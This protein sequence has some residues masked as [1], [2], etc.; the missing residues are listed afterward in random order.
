MS[1]RERKRAERQKRKRRSAERE[2]TDAE[3]PAS[4]NG[5]RP[6]TRSELKDREAREALVPLRED[7]RP[8]IVTAAAVI[9]VLLVLLSAIGYALWDVL[10]DDARPPV[11][12]VAVFVVLFSVMAWGLWRARYWAVLGFQTVLVF[13]L[14]LSSLALIQATTV[15]EAVGDVALMAGAGF[16]FYRMVKAMAR[17]QMPERLPR[18]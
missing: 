1:D 4:G 17:I 18:E 15:L 14:V 16:L 3:A 5:E 11:G 8:G 12:G 6:L 13:V 7:E 10:R 2:L 9:S